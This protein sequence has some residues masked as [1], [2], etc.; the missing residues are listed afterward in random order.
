MSE[1]D[2]DF[3]EKVFPTLV[4]VGMVHGFMDPDFAKALMD[5]CIYEKHVQKL[6]DEALLVL[7]DQVTKKPMS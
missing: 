1:A 7:A 6:S 2:F 5:E 3:I 4:K